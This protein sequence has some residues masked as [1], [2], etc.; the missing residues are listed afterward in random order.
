M[1]YFVNSI[2]ISTIHI[3]DSVWYT[4]SIYVSSYE[5]YIQYSLIS[6]L[7]LLIIGLMVTDLMSLTSCFIFTDQYA[8]ICLKICTSRLLHHQQHSD[9]CSTSLGID[10]LSQNHG[11]DSFAY[12]S[13]WQVKIQCLSPR[14][15]LRL[16]FRQ[17]IYS[18]VGISRFIFICSYTHFAGRKSI[19][20]KQMPIRRQQM[21]SMMTWTTSQRDLILCSLKALDLLL[22]TIQVVA[23]VLFLENLG[24]GYDYFLSVTYCL[25]IER[26]QLYPSPEC[27]SSF[28]FCHAF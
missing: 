18:Y 4:S 23:M 19:W 7:I 25:E 5:D 21:Q 6:S 17:I 1:T 28:G 13:L 2:V 3:Y 27:P 9:R 10:L 24:V 14:A 12:L 15:K 26:I 16:T 20:K 11:N 8:F 22:V